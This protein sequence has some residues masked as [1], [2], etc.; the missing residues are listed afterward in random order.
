M[1]IE[2]GSKVKDTVTGIE[3]ITVCRLTYL[4]GCERYEVQPQGTTRDGE[5]IKSNWVDVDQLNVLESPAKDALEAMEEKKAPGG[6]RTAP[7]SMSTP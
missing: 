6:D 4:N 1:T 3:G 2:L 7:P 5:V